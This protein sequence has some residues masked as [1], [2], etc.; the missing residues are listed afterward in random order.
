MIV[1]DLL[2]PRFCFGCGS[3][4]SY[5]CLGCEAGLV[6]A[7]QRCFYCQ[8]KS[9]FGQ[10]H[11]HCQKP[12][13]IDGCVSLYYYNSG[14]K[15]II[16]KIKYS[17]ITD[18]TREILPVLLKEAIM[19]LSFYKKNFGKVCLQPVPLHP[20]KEKNR[21]FNQSDIISRYLSCF[22][23]IKIVGVVKRKK[24]TRPQAELSHPQERLYNI[25]GA[26]EPN[27]FTRSIP[28]SLILVDDVITTGSTIKEL[29]RVLKKKGVARVFAFSL[30][31]G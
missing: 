3:I 21:G 30:A 8:K 9:P 24:N 31:K 6:L 29:A 17:L 1:E 25:K 14:L 5:L 16:K 11:S 2:F 27:L 20:Q 18:S 22:F 28:H 13:G 26:F 10:T 23:D 7:D 12:W 19:P 4:G 15:K